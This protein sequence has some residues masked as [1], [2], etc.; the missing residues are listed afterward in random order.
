MVGM[1]E[2][3]DGTIFI[4]MHEGYRVGQRI[5]GQRFRV[6]ER[7]PVRA[8]KRRGA[9]E[10]RRKR[11][12]EPGWSLAVPGG[13]GIGSMLTGFGEGACWDAIGGART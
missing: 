10:E 1:A 3:G 7:G 9:G 4:A 6:T 11:R 2:L 5:R 12:E 13:D 8:P